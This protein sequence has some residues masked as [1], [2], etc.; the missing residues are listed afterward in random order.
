M[1]LPLYH[2]VITLSRFPANATLFLSGSC[3]NSVA[4]FLRG[5][6]GKQAGLD[7]FF[8]DRAFFR[9]RHLHELEEQF[10]RVP[11][12]FGKVVI[13]PRDG[14]RIG[15][16]VFG[17][18]VTGD[19]NVL[20]HLQPAFFQQI[21]QADCYDVAV[22]DQPVRTERKKSVEKPVA[23]CFRGKA[24]RRSQLEGILFW[25]AETVL[26][27]DFEE[28]VDPDVMH[29]VRDARRDQ[30]RRPA[31]AREKPLNQHADACPL[32]LCDKR[33]AS[34]SDRFMNEYLVGETFEQ[35]C[36]FC[37]EFKIS[38]GTADD[39][40]HVAG[41]KVGDLFFNCPEVV[42]LRPDLEPV[43]G[44]A[45]NLLDRRH[46]GDPVFCALRIKDISDDLAAAARKLPRRQIR[47]VVQFLREPLDFR[48]CFRRNPDGT[49]TRIERLGDGHTADSRHG[50]NIADARFS[51]CVVWLSH[52]GGN[53]VV[54]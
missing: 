38:M 19:R 29:A 39:S 34:G 2:S 36:D 40:V 45:E 50:G 27:H 33:D 28:C 9:F 48:P 37:P 3:K 20:R 16:S 42:M 21:D 22:N 14:G 49:R 5:L 35:R 32:I 41:V 17:M 24:A 10:R 1:N 7:I 51:R 53:S 15:F 23:A 44:F 26:P 47:T 12:D 25:T 4:F 30:V 8:H 11:P 52:S 54:K 18:A 13:Q 6:A 31:S 43:S 46:A